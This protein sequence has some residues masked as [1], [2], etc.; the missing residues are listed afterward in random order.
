MTNQPPPSATSILAAGILNTHD[1]TELRVDRGAALAG[2]ETALSS[3]LQGLNSTAAMN[4]RH[5]RFA[6]PGTRPEDFTEHVME[7]RDGLV[8]CGIRHAGLDPQRPFVQLGASFPIEGPEHARQVATGFSDLFAPFSPLAVQYWAA[9][10]GDADYIGSV[11]LV[12]EAEELRRRAPWRT[13]ESLELRRVEDDGYY[14]WYRRGYEAFHARH[15]QLRHKVPVN[16]KEVM[17]VCRQAG[18]VSLGF[19]K[20]D[21]VGLVAAEP[22]PLLGR[23][24]LYFVELFVD[25]A[26]RGRRLA[27]ALQRAFVHQFGTPEQLVWGTI[28]ADNL[29]SLRTA[30]SNGRRAIRYECFAP[31]RE[32]AGARFG[33]RYAPG[34]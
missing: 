23:D 1:L 28:A 6:I 4:K 20:G 24:G 14:D 7:T 25:Q 11:Y 15:P 26:W 5:Q 32:G 33:T 8:C 2:L 13:E 18:L 10:P 9:T 21:P 27:P 3:A 29:P 30:L 12:Q 34:T 17:E 19:I 31:L 22:T 16:D